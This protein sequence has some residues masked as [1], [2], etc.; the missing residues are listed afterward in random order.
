LLLLSSLW[1][2]ATHVLLFP[3]MWTRFFAAQYAIGFA[4][5]ILLLPELLRRKERSI[6][7]RM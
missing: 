3:A 5:A 1:Y 6:A 2:V 7:E 4:E